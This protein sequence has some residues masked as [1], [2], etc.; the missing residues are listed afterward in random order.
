VLLAAF[1]G[2]DW[3]DA[4]AVALDRGYRFLSFGDAMYVE[5]G[6]LLP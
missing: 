3:R 6:Q 2:P 4:Y 1:M 5:R